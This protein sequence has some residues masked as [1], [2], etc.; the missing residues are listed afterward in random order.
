MKTGKTKLKAGCG[1]FMVFAAGFLSGAIVLFLLLVK[2]I[3]LSE[4]WRDEESKQ[5]VI[6]HLSSRLSLTEEQLERARPIVYEA[7]DQRYAHR[8]VYVEADIELTRAAFEELKPILTP[9]QRE[10]A[11]GMFENWRNGKK[12]FLLGEKQKPGE[13]G[14]SDESS[15]PTLREAPGNASAGAPAESASE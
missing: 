11:T 5:F 10:K 9:E 15:A 6:D 13:P 3:P 7:L 4:G 8:K 1:L 2:I 14:G 12:R